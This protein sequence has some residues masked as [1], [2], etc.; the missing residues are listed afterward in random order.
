MGADDHAKH[1]AVG[2]CG[3]SDFPVCRHRQSQRAGLRPNGAFRAHQSPLPHG[4]A[5]S[6]AQHNQ[7]L[8]PIDLGP[9]RNRRIPRKTTR[10]MVP[11]R[12]GER[13]HGQ[14][15]VAAA[16]GGRAGTSSRGIL[17]RSGDL[18]AGQTRPPSAWL[19]AKGCVLAWSGSSSSTVGTF[20]KRKARV[21][22]R[23]EQGH[24]TGRW[25]ITAARS[26]RA[27]SKRYLQTHTPDECPA[28]RIPFQT[29]SGRS[30][31]AAAAR[32]YRG[33]G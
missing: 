27:S 14:R 23:P 33:T 21:P 25:R 19:R 26:V 20:R 28:L 15:P 24:L 4:I 17:E 9:I 22:V 3:L 11:P 13:A 16:G 10:T 31:E 5:V 12:R 29:F 2:A 7:R 18:V 6:R 8:S 32:P 30:R 1:G